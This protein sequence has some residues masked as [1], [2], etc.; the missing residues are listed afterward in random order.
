MVA[1]VSENGVVSFID[2]LKENYYKYLPA[3][4]DRNLNQVIFATEPG[5]GAAILNV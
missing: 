5:S 2:H 1:L 4:D 3:A